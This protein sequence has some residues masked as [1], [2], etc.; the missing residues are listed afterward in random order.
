MPDHLLVP[1]LA[2]LIIILVFYIFYLR[3]LVDTWKES[4]EK[5]F[6]ENKTLGH[7]NRAQ[8]EVIGATRKEVSNL[9]NRPPPKPEK[10]DSYE[11][12]ELLHDLTAG[13][14]LIEIKRIAPSSVFL[15]S[16]R[17]KSE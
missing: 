10:V 1:A 11:V 2:S 12:Q 13:K 7:A 17:E 6:G 16:P 8:A 14:A 3:R 4:S 9:K 15:R 5:L